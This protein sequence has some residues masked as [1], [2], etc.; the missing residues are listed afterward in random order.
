MFG[1]ADVWRTRT[2]TTTDRAIGAISAIVAFARGGSVLN[3]CSKVL[4]AGLGLSLAAG[5]SNRATFANLTIPNHN[6]L[7]F[8]CIAARHA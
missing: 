3:R 1:R 8:S 2:D 7:L 5:K 4:T 6:W